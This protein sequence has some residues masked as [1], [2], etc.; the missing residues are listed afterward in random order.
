MTKPLY[1]VLGLTDDAT[2]EDI[3]RAYRAKAKE[4]HPDKPENR[5]DEAKKKMWEAIKTALRRK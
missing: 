3:K 1:A 4:C 2:I 5:D